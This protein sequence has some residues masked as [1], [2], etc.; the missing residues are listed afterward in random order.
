[1][2]I[3]TN[4]VESKMLHRIAKTEAKKLPGGLFGPRDPKLFP[5]LEQNK[6]NKDSG[7]R[8]D[9]HP[10]F[11]RWLEPMLIAAGGGPGRM[12]AFDDP[13]SGL[14]LGALRLDVAHE[15]HLRAALANF[16]RNRLLD[17]DSAAPG[18][19]V[20]RVDLAALFAKQGPRMTANERAQAQ[21]LANRLL[22]RP[23]ALA[24]LR[25]RERA[26]LLRI[27]LAVRGLIQTACPDAADFAR[28]LRGQLEFACHLRQF[29]TGDIAPLAAFLAGREVSFDGADGRSRRLRLRPPLT[30]EGFRDLRRATRWGASHPRACESRHTRIDL[31]FEKFAV[32]Q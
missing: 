2:T 17:L 29:G 31:A 20:V 8:P 12:V 25:R 3:A 26:T 10:L 21:R 5:V 24:L 19:P 14:A 18:A 32:P 9:L 27:G 13:D 11:V 6:N 16:A 1:M 15:P 28:D 23:A 22:E 7:S 30:R 4:K